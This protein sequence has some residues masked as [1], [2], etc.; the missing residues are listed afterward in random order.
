MLLIKPR[1][2]SKMTLIRSRDRARDSSPSLSIF[3]LNT[4]TNKRCNAVK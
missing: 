1:S 2:K 4:A 3:F